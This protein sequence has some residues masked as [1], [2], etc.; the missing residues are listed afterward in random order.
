MCG[1]IAFKGTSI[2]KD[3]LAFPAKKLIHRGPDDQKYISLEN[4]Y[5]SFQRLA[6]MDLSDKGDQPFITEDQTKYLM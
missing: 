5:L 2:T 6:I 4:A 1:L 3:K